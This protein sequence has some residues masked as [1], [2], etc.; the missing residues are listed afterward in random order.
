MAV[1]QKQSKNYNRNEEVLT[2]V[3]AREDPG[4]PSSGIDIRSSQPEGSYNTQTLRNNCGAPLSGLAKYI[5]IYQITLDIFVWNPKENDQLN[6]QRQI[7]VCDICCVFAIQNY[8]NQVSPL[9]YIF[10]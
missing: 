9:Q 4:S 7:L 6:I 3:L 1:Q 8:Q 10:L 2:G 5:Y